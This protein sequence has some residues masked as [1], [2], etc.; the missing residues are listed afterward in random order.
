MVKVG[1]MCSSR[2]IYEAITNYKDVPL[3]QN[4]ALK[5]SAKQLDFIGP[6]SDFVS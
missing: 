6:R 5:Y 1:G 3:L 2:S 4:R